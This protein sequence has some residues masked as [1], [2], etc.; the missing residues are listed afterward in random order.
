LVVFSYVFLANAWIADDAAIT[1]RAVWN[2]VN[3]YGLTYNPDERVQS[4]THPLWALA[5]AGPHALTGEF[6]FTVTAL[7]WA[8]NV[9]A[10]VVLLRRVRTLGGAALTVAWLLSSKALVDYTSSGLEYPLSYFLL[11]LF[12]TRYLNR[13]HDTGI[14]PAEL[15]WYI[16]VASLAFVNR[17][18]AVLLYVVPLIGLLWRAAREHRS[19]IVRPILIG[20]SPAL[21][22]VAFATF[23]YG[24]P[25]PNTYYAKVANDLPAFL[26]HEQGV[27]YLF[28]SIRFDPLTI[29]TIALA[30]VVAA[31]MKGHARLAALSA[32]VSVGYTVDIGGDFMSGRFFAL[33]F[34][35]AVIAIVPVIETRLVPWLGAGLV[36]Y[37]VIMPLA[38]IKTTASTDGGWS[39]RTQNGIKDERGFTH[40]GS[41]VL[42]YAP[43]RLLPDSTYARQGVSMTGSDRHAVVVC[44]IG[45]FG[46]NAGP[47][48][49][50]ID[51]MALADPLLARLPVSPRVYFEFWASHYL[52]D[53]PDGY[54]ESNELNQ[55]L[56]TDPFLHAYYDRLRE[57]TRG[58]L[59]RWSRY[60]SIWAL[61]LGPDRNMRRTYEKHR[62]IALSIRA[63]NDRF[64]T[65]VGVRDPQAG[66]LSTTARQ[67][68]LQFGPGIPMKA[69]TYRARWEGTVSASGGLPLGYVEVWNGSERIERQAV[70][71]P[72]GSSQVVAQVDFSLPRDARS[73]EYRFWVNDT[74]SISLAR[75]ALYSVTAIPADE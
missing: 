75:I 7:S 43:F 60:R 34:L 54:L 14:T 44:C 41:N 17:P 11:A 49:H 65:D 42:G 27:A 2:F 73:L 10:G 50:V 24:F 72:T 47:T 1:F 29:G 15:R 61:N 40:Q 67:G 57:V 62:P 12:Y 71:S 26:Q 64:L 36:L 55:N 53:L 68:Y 32:L 8:F 4:F 51:T 9:A 59:W 3:G 33:P 6:F 56:L 38:P 13:R 19:A 25:L 39:W 5:I 46:L 18:D 74:A 22:W 21:A 31:S 70:P 52:R 58:P 37:N 20:G 63:D 30:L 23:Y 45:L 28:N 48:K 16:V 69:G 35:V 66:R